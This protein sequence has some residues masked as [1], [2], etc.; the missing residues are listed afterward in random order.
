MKTL[1]TF[2]LL[3]S[4]TIVGLFTFNLGNSLDRTLA[5]VED[6]TA[7]EIITSKSRITFGEG[8]IE[9]TDVLKISAPEIENSN[10][11]TEIE[12][13]NNFETISPYID[14]QEKVID[15]EADVIKGVFVE[16]V[17]GFQVIQQPEGQPAYVS[18][19]KGIVT[20]FN[21]AENYGSIGLMAHNYLS[22]ENYFNLEIGQIVT[23][24]FGDGVTQNFNIVDIQ[25]YQALSPNSVNSEFIKL[26]NTENRVSAERLFKEIYAHNGNL[27]FQ[28]CIEKENNLTWGRLFVI[29]SPIT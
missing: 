11:V 3:S 15:G 8:D 29:A 18:P 23:V 2:G 9:T 16:D 12:D 14:L 6:S 13:P 22:G 10:N 26:D 17:L 24:I 7:R 4:I 28:T 20:Q 1:L 5:V 19:M 27:V 25:Q 21:L